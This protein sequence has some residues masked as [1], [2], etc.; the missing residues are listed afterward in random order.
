MSHTHRSRLRQWFTLIFILSVTLQPVVPGG[1]A[2]L[3]VVAASTTTQPV[4]A[5]LPAA[6]YRTLT[7]AELLITAPNTLEVTASGIQPSV[8]EVVVSQTV[9]LLNSDTRLRRLKLSDAPVVPGYK[10]YLPLIKRDASG[11]LFAPVSIN[12]DQLAAPTGTEIITLSAG[13]SVTRTFTTVGNLYV[14]DADDLAVSAA[15]LLVTPLPLAKI[16]NVSGLVRDFN[17]K[18]VIGGA[19]ITTVESPTLQTTSDA[20]GGYVLSLPPGDFTLVVFANGYTFAN[21]KISVASYT[22][23]GVEPLE[24]VPLDPVVTAIGGAGGVVTNAL[25]T[26]NVIFSNGAVTAT[27]A[28]RLTE[29]PVD[30]LAADF[31]ALPGPFTDGSVPLGFVMFEPDGTQFS[32][33]VTWTIAYSGSLPIGAPVPCYYWLE[34]EA[35]WGQ[36]VPGHVIDLGNGNKGLQAILP[37]FSAYG[38]APP[39]PPEPGAPDSPTAP[40]PADPGGPND[41]PNCG[42]QDSPCGSLLNQMSG[43]LSQV[44]GTLGLPNAGGLPTQITARYRSLAMDQQSILSTVFKLSPIRQVPDAEQWQFD[45]AGRTFTAASFDVYVPWDGKDGGGNLL[46]PGVYSGTLTME[47]RYL[48]YCSGPIP[49]TNTQPIGWSNFRSTTVWPLRVTRNDL[50]P[51]GLG[52]FSPH[53]TLLTDNGTSASIVQADGRQVV[54]MRQAANYLTPKG[55]FG[56]LAHNADGTW[57]RAYPDGSTL[58]FNADGRL[59]RISDRYG[60]A[61]VLLYESNGHSV[62]VGHWGL[63]TR[64]RRVADTTGNTFDYGYDANGWLASITDHTGRVYGFEHDADGHLTAAIDPLGQRET[65][66]YDARG[67]MTSHTDR[68]HATTSYVLDDLGRLLTRTWPTGTALQMS[69][70]PTQTTTLTDRGTPRV[71]QMDNRFNPAAMYNG[72]YTVTM[73]YTDQELPQSTTRPPQATLYDASGNVIE[74]VAAEYALFARNG[75]YDQVSRQTRSDGTDTQYSY[76]AAGN[77]TSATDVL[78][79]TYQMTYNAQGQPLS[80]RDPLGHVTTLLYNPRGQVAAVTNALNQTV[81]FNYDAGGRLISTIDPLNH[82]TTHEYDALNRLTAVVDALNGRTTVRYDANANLTGITDPTGRV[83]S[84]TYD[85]LNRRTVITYPD[86]GQDTYGY[87]AL[88]NVLTS[89]NALGQLITRSYDA[90]NRLISRNVAGGPTLNYSFDTLDQLTRIGDGVLTTTLNYIPGTLDK[91]LR[92]QQLKWELAAQHHAGI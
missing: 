60:N 54:F 36:P 26:T 24:L 72:V 65:F 45:I 61:Q 92:E 12:F 63:T 52:W 2:A 80:I 39:P 74:V 23:V 27:K 25:N 15:T 77:L 30:P 11:L 35:R 6:T 4:V 76:D 47:Y 66:T 40:G 7:D 19:H 85:A 68:R 38:F 86:G 81:Q 14:S 5:P 78:G 37:H 28:V 34:S 88:G 32:G 90:A 51:F 46:A 44:V 17:T 57:T 53:D 87:D 9:T 71:V 18:A 89:T 62:P 79:Q 43:G 64:L 22:P 3:S 69:Y 49:C 41:N 91:E 29:L 75:P 33:P 82:T 70:V 59:T 67:M 50:S 1:R 55:D 48:V 8:L 20:Q 21:R 10:L 56:T 58:T 84:Y 31:K 83:I 13:Q 16:G 42:N 73:T